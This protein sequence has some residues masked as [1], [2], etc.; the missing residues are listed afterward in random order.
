MFYNGENFVHSLVKTT[1]TNIQ[2]KNNLREVL[3]RQTS[4]SKGLYA[5]KTEL[6]F[7]KWKN[8]EYFAGL[9]VAS[10]FF[11]QFFY[12]FFVAFTNIQEIVFG[13]KKCKNM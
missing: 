4:T 7:T 5:K 3:R 8:M 11:D 9:I 13:V 6:F 1:K 12:V 10:C 2:T